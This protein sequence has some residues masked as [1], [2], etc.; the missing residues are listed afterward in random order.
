MIRGLDHVQIAIPRDAEDS[1][2]EFYGGLLEMEEVAKP[3]ALA[4]RGGC[5]F[6][7]GTAMLHLGAEEPFTPARKAHPAFLVTDLDD[8]QER[9]EEAGHSCTRS[10]NQLPGVRRFHTNDP[11]DNRIE[12]QQE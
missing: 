8:L 3:P 7:S 10:D 6:T 12:F 9:L 5:W 4:A 11:F 2:R 1:A